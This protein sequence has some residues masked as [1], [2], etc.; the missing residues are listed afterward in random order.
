[1]IE[2]KSDLITPAQCRAARA[3]LDMTQ[4]DL[5]ERSGLGL[6]TVVDFEKSR[7]QVSDRAIADLRSALERAGVRFVREQA[8]IGVM[9]QNTK[10]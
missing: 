9:T 2:K 6:S 1:M 4:P 8:A 5:A 10:K 7:R 3:L